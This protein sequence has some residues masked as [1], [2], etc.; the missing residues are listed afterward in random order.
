MNPVPPVTVVDITRL[1]GYTIRL[2]HAC[3]CRQRKSYTR[4]E[5]PAIPFGVAQTRVVALRFRGRLNGSGSN[6]PEPSSEADR[7]DEV[8]VGHVYRRAFRG[9]SADISSS[10]LERLREDPRVASVEPEYG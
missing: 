1:L 9:Y 6:E 5:Y 7:D 4:G 10:R 2:I 3:C 8:E